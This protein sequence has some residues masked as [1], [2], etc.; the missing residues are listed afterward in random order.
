MSIDWQRAA[1][2]V[3]AVDA[4]QQILLTQFSK[5][6]HPKSG[7]WT[8]PGGGME[9]GEQAHETA[10][11]E[12]EEETGLCADIGPLLGAQSEWFDERTSERRQC[13]L[14][15]RL[16]FKARNCEGE[17]K[18]DFRGDDTTVGAAWFSIDA[19]QQLNR[20]EVVD[21]GLSLTSINEV[22]G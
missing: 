2:Y 22:A 5:A 20:V 11:R 17:L 4:N 21:F 19:V 14:A 7:A 1:A 15:L 8:L 12:L 6:G 9:W 3:V 10:L 18:T 13:G 16:I